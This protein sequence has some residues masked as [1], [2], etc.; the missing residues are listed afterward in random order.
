MRS[1]ERGGSDP[2]VV[3][4]AGRPGTRGQL[5]LSAIEAAIGVTFVLA[6]ATSFAVAPADPG[7]ATADLDASAT[8]VAT[9]LANEGRAGFGDGTAAGRP[10]PAAI[11]TAETF[12]AERD[13]IDARAEALVPDRLQYHVETPHGDVGITPPPDATVG[14]SAIA[15]R[16][17]RIVVAVWR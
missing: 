3:L 10:L 5:S 11:A 1:C 15:T 7:V 14:R 12:A 4:D 6:I 9:V 17:G 16:N 2:T 8:D 13:A